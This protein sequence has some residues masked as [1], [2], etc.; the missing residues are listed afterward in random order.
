[1]AKRTLGAVLFEG[2]ELLDL[3]GP[4]EMFG[5]LG[6]DLTIVTLAEEAGPVRSG[7]GPATVAEHAFRTAPACDLYLV[8]GG[9]GV[10]GAQD[11]A[12]M[13]E[14]LRKA[15]GESELLMSVCNG[16]GI[17]ASAG[18]LDGRRATTNKIFFDTVRSRS[19][20]T[21]WVE[22][23]RWVH[24]GDIATSSGVSAGADMALAMI[25][26]LYGEERANAVAVL[27]EWN[28]HEDADADP[29]AE[30][31]N[32]THWMATALNLGKSA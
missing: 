9:P 21:E 25:A 8:P 22:S 32:E 20:K 5:C 23:A 12:A 29:F 4:L 3:Y 11:N 28:R 30:H 15:H 18:V 19:E 27:A 6:E 7:F 14:F 1:M 31:L 13:L 10:F 2:F 26:Q 17:L 24:D 16:A